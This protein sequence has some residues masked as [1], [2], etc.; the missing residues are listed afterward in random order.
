MR[1]A[2]ANL[3]ISRRTSP[4]AAVLPFGRA[5][6]LTGLVL[7]LIVGGIRFLSLPQPAGA[8]GFTSHIIGVET[9][10]VGVL[11]MAAADLDDDNDID[12]VTAGSDGLKVYINNNDGTFAPKIVDD[13]RGQRVQII[14]LD[15][16]GAQ[17]LLVTT[18]DSTSSVRWYRNTGGIEFSGTIIGV[19]GNGKAYAGDIDADGAPDIITATTAGD[20]VTLQ[21]WMNNGTG[22]F[23]SITLAT[24]AGVTAITIADVNNNGFN[25]IVTGGSAGLQRWDTSDGYSWSRID[26]DDSNTDQEYLVVADVNEDGKQDIVAAEPAG[27]LVLLY[28]NVDLTVFQRGEVGT[29]VD[30]MTVVP[31]DLDEDGDEDIVVAAQ[32]NNSVYWYDNN[33]SEE[34]TRTTITN[35]LQSV[36]GV[37]VTDVDNDNDFDVLAGDHYRGNVYWYERIAAKPVAT[38]P[39]EITQST[40]GQGLVTFT[41]KISD[42]DRDPTRLRVQYSVDGVNWY[43]P[44]LTSARADTGSVDL[45]N[46]NGYQIGTSN[47]IDTNASDS[48]KLTMVWDTQ[49]VS[50][51][52]GPI[53]GDITTVRLRFIPRDDVGNGGTITGDSFQVDNEAPHL[54]TMQVGEVGENQVVFTWDKATDSNLFDYALY[55]GTSHTAVLDKTSAVWDV[56]D[57]ATMGDEETTGVTVMGLADGLKYTFKLFVTDIFGNETGVQSVRVTTGQAAETLTSTG[58]ASPTT[59]VTPTATSTPEPTT[60]EP[61]VPENLPPVAQAGKDQ[62]VNSEALV[63]LD[64]TNSYDPEGGSLSYT[65]RQLKGREAKLSSAYAATSSFTAMGE[66][67]VYIFSLAVR[68]FSGLTATDTVTIVTRALPEAA[69]TEPAP[70]EVIRI[71]EKKREVP[72]IVSLILRPLDIFLFVL[73][74]LAT[75]V[76]LLDRVLHS[77]GRKHVEQV[78]SFLRGRRGPVHRG[79]VVQYKT[80]E[81]IAG[82]QVLIYG[83]DKR[84]KHKLRTNARGVFATPLVP[85]D[86]TIAIKAEG[87]VFSP[88]A[89]TFEPGEGEI[90]YTGGTLTIVDQTRVVNF[91]IPMKPTGEA[92]SSWRIRTLRWWQIAQRRGHVLS[93]PVF[94]SGSLL[95]TALLLMASN[96]LFLMLEIFYVGLVAVKV[97]LEIRLR[98]SYGLVRDAITHVPLDLAV[99]RLYEQGTNRLVMTRV[100]DGSGRFFALPPPGRYVVTIT[101]PGYASF[102][103]E[104][105]E[106]TSTHDSKLQMKADLMPVAPQLG[107]ATAGI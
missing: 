42:G 104:G 49:S 107:M 86:Y 1:R 58:E 102:T 8:L 40:D 23:A 88:A 101:K 82:V 53:V 48:V 57:D 84:V 54:A 38:E 18:R 24:N 62:V 61:I 93:W 77:V 22:T 35:S 33:G 37:I 6:V 50:N 15:M 30:A 14:D 72:A 87:F 20:S 5:L 70:A 94:I 34:F 65:W 47:R 95:N 25:D 79:R 67:E 75:I 103:R 55:Y 12:V 90:I 71:E 78:A 99:V 56:S 31:V 43:K 81:P 74:L 91:V 105:V 36:F 63:I 10:A 100:A 27:N 29:E 59:L 32:D 3:K 21:R 45:K 106:I 64:G 83:R 80:G 9:G 76:S 92:L 16:D 46:S 41:T 98:P 26:I 7:A 73:A 96:G 66:S 69:V 4:W 44:W 28:R 17:D 85:G 39:E 97:V 13:I 51:T 19:N 60:S 68:D 89:A 11:G 2:A 52:G